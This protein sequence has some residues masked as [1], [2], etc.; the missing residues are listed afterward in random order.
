MDT[1]ELKVNRRNTAA[2]IKDKPTSIA[3][4]HP[5]TRDPDGAGGFTT[6][7]AQPVGPQDFRLVIQGGN[8]ASRNIDGEQISPAYVM[9]GEWDADI[10]TGDTFS[11]NGR[12]YEVKFVREDREYETWAEVVY[13]G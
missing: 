12:N 11:H 4:T 6:T 3:L 13:R 2:Y 7:P 8:V 5:A 9:I 10:K 1:V